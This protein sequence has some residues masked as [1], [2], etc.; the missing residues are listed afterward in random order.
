MYQLG[1][2]LSELIYVRSNV[3]FKAVSG[4]ML[5]QHRLVLSSK[6]EELGIR[7]DGKS[8]YEIFGLKLKLFDLAKH[9]L[10][11]PAEEHMLQR[12]NCDLIRDRTAPK[13]G[14]AQPVDATSIGIYIGFS[15]SYIAVVDCSCASKSKECPEP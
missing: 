3:S 7:V 8:N 6:R 5:L 4:A 10:A 9:L 14:R 12:P 15:T 11:L 13:V 1:T 2:V